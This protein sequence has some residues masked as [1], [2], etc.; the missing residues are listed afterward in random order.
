[1]CRWNDRDKIL[2]YSG[3]KTELGVCVISFYSCDNRPLSV[4]PALRRTWNTC[5]LLTGS[6][7][8]GIRVVDSMFANCVYFFQPALFIRSILDIKWVFARAHRFHLNVNIFAPGQLRKHWSDVGSF[9]NSF[10]CKI[11]LCRWSPPSLVQHE[12]KWRA[13]LGNLPKLILRRSI[14]AKIIWRK[15][16]CPYIARQ[17]Y[18]IISPVTA[19]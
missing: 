3:K 12:H 4:R 13:S 6:R 16:V 19:K 1:M 18:C 8:S 5:P 17:I 11:S 9:Y 15:F 14:F 10:C 2:S 7:K